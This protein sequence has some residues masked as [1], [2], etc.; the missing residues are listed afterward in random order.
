MTPLAIA[1]ALLLLL[2]VAVPAPREGRLGAGVLVLL[3]AVL[4]GA[5]L[6]KVA[7]TRT[8]YVPNSQTSQVLAYAIRELAEAHEPNVLLVDGGSYVQ[9]GLDA[10][11]LE[12]DLA[13]LGYR[14]RVVRLSLTGAN[15]FERLQLYEDITARLPRGVK[16][17]PR[18]I[19]MI[20]VQE[21]YD[22][23]PLAQFENN[24]DTA[25]AY[26]YLTP[27]NVWFALTADYGGGSTLPLDWHGRLAVLRHALINGFNV[28]LLERLTTLDA[29]AP[30][31]PKI[32]K[33][34]GRRFAFDGTSTLVAEAGQA[35]R[36]R[37]MPPWLLPVRD[38]HLREVWGP[39]I[40]EWLY[41]ALPSTA[42]SQL[43]HAR[44]FCLQARSPC[45]A[46]DDAALLQR[47]ND[48]QLW[49]DAGH[50]SERGSRVYTHWL[51][52]QLAKQGVLEK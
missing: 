33:E 49:F 20:E 44:G 16:Q 24:Q 21:G 31:R 41:F 15:H 14:V 17:S 13:E 42:L 51:A 47:L 25:R 6:V 18:W 7:L 36:P 9:R 43:E 4:G 46:P 19:F 10:E 27:I 2:V 38:R 3:L 23:Q 50:L 35:A 11:L 5:A 26:H 34:R 37:D 1:A 30:A 32:S 52:Q 12:R 29:V 22:V 39:Y 8:S 40:D 48:K 28:G 45:I